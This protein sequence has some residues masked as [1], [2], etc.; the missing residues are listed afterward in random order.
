M[1]LHLGCGEDKIPDAVTLDL[2][3]AVKP[4]HVHNL[5]VFPWPFTDEQFD[6]VHALDVIE[7]LTDVIKTMDEIHRISKP[8]AKLFIRTCYWRSENAFTDPTH[9]HFFTL[10]SFD[11]FDPKTEFGKKYGFYSEKK[12]SIERKTID[13]SDIVLDM[14]RL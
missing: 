12:W 9:K 7:H 4:D 13:G 2:R 6:E 1:K 11:Y 3:E 8:G 10:K 14:V 5:E